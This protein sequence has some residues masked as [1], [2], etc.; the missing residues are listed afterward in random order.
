MYCCLLYPKYFLANG[1]S[2][3]DLASLRN[4]SPRGPVCSGSAETYSQH[5]TTQ[6]S[7]HPQVRPSP[8]QQLRPKSEGLASSLKLATVMLTLCV[9]LFSAPRR[10]FLL[11]LKLKGL[12]KTKTPNQTVQHLIVFP[13]PPKHKPLSRPGAAADSVAKMPVPEPRRTS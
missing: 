2:P 9:I 13:V 4:G 10:T 8:D 3:A 6:D 11:S 7:N 5:R 1:S 12:N